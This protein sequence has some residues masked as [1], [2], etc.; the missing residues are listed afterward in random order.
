MAKQRLA[1]SLSSGAA[2]TALPPVLLRDA[3]RAAPAEWQPIVAAL[4]HFGDT[5]EIVPRVFGAPFLEHIHQQ[6]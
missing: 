1:F 3:A 2:L 4:L 6:N 5:I